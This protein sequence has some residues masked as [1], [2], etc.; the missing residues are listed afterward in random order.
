MV[1]L[2]MIAILSITSEWSQ[3]TGL[4]TF[5]LVPHRSRIIPAKAFASVAIAIA[6]DGVH[7]LIG[8][9]GNLVGAA[10]AAPPWCGT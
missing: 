4:T 7:L 3:R 5:T 1:I 6:A 9:V 10:I 2:P 8:A